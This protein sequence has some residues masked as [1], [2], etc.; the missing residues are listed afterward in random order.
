MDIKI[1][2]TDALSR[3]VANLH[4]DQL[5]PKVVDHTKL[6]ILDFLASAVAGRKVN[7]VFN[8]TIVKVFGSMGGSEE[9]SILFGDKKL[10]SSNAAFINAVYGHGADLDDGHR[11]AQ[12][13]P[14]VTVIPAVLAL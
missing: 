8:K 11:T 1:N 10:P 3:Y 7:P 2:S 9:S 6:V 14:G 12:G 5:P 13:H 4:Y